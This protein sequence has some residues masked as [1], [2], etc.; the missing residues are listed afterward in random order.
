MKNYIKDNNIKRYNVLQDKMY[1]SDIEEEDEEEE[2]E[3]IID[4]ICETIEL[5]TESGI[6]SS[7]E[8][9][10]VLECKVFLSDLE[11]K[12]DDLG[13]YIEELRKQLRNN[14]I[15]IEVLK[16]EDKTLKND[17]EKLFKVIQ[18]MKREIN[19]LII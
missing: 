5:L 11:E 8:L 13:E 7:D 16:K 19:D 18:N 3:D 1:F 15:E 9:Y 4:G 17:I 12:D 2:E 14:Y 10:D 6:E